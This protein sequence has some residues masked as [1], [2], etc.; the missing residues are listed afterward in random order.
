MDLTTHLAVGIFLYKV[1]GNPWLILLSVI[2]DFDHLFGYLYDSRKKIRL[3]IPK[4]YRLAYRPRS[5]FHSILMVP[6]LAIIFLQIVPWKQSVLALT[7]HLLLD[8]PDREGIYIVPFL[9][10]KKIRGPLPVAYYIKHEKRK[11]KKSFHIIS[12]T[13][14]TIF[15]LLSILY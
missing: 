3:E 8:M 6:I 13:L 14:T 15:I 4:L 9:S 2:F 11:I 10:K 7:I 12:L 1:F 5:W